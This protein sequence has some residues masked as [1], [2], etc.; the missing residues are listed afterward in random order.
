MKK[1]KEQAAIPLSENP[2]LTIKSIVEKMATLDREVKY[3]I[4][5]AKNWR[6]PKKAKEDKKGELIFIFVILS[7]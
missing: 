5:K 2:K 4:N 6:P 7:I 3:L 1:V